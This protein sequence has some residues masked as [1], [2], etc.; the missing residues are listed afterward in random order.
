MSSQM[1]VKSVPPTFFQEPLPERQAV[2]SLSEKTGLDAQSAAMQSR[3]TQV[4]N[5]QGWTT[6]S[7]AT[8]SAAESD[9]AEVAAEKSTTGFFEVVR[10]YASVSDM[11]RLFGAAA[12]AVAMGLFLLDGVKV[13]NDLQR[14][15]TMLGLTGALTAAGLLMSSLLKEQRGSRVFITLALLSVPVNFTVIGA[16]L[17]SVIPL[18][19]MALNYPG[20]AHWQVGGLSDLAIGLAAAVV[21]LG[22]VVWAGFSVLARSACAWLSMALIASSAI[23]LIPVRA[24]LW[25]AGIACLL[26]TS[27]S[28]RDKRQSRMPSSA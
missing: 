4:Q 16:L 7:V 22:P 1:P 13:L 19:T 2:N 28:P 24:E 14:F 17:Y 10:K 20:Y 6:H 27:P 18:D 8:T 15:L 26:Y 3:D 5:A 23:L 25:S 21:V 12:V 11:L 9:R